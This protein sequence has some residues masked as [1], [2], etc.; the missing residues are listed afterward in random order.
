[1]NGDDLSPVFRGRHP[2]RRR[3]AYGGYANNFYV[4][5]DRWTLIGDNR[6]RRLR[7]YDT[8]A[9]PG[10][11]RDVAGAH[12]AKAREL[13]AAVMRRAGGRLPSYPER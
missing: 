3:F 2:P 6:G 4:R 7:L 10:E 9:D 8:R 11:R 12:R 5:T 1:M 13:Y